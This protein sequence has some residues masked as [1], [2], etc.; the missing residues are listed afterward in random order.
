MERNEELLRAVADYIEEDPKRH[1]QSCWVNENWDCGTT[2]CIAG[3]AL[4][5][6]GYKYTART[7]NWLTPN[8]VFADVD[9][10]TFEYAK[11]ELGL[12]EVDAQVLFGGHWKPARHLTI[13]DALRKL[14]GGADIK[15][16]TYDRSRPPL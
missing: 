6:S 8:G 1:T 12:T 5:L 13:G 3:N 2:G 4:L 10:N 15:E 14:A 11:R 9:D 7:N 16:V